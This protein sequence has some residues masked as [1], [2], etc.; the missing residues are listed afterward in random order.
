VGGGAMLLA[1]WMC[2]YFFCRAGSDADEWNPS[3]LMCKV[4]DVFNK[5]IMIDE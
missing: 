1:S 2:P 3:A 5:N 4:A